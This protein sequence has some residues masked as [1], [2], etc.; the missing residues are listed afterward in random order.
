[1]TSSLALDLIAQLLLIERR[2]F[3]PA[4]WVPPYQGMPE[5]ERALVSAAVAIAAGASGRARVALAN[6]DWSSAPAGGGGIADRYVAAALG[7]CALGL[8]F[9]WFPGDVGATQDDAEPVPDFV[10]RLDGTPLSEITVDPKL[11]LVRVAAGLVFRIH[12]SR[13][14]VSDCQALPP[15][16]RGG[17]EVALMTWRQALAEA[18]PL[19]VGPDAPPL[20]SAVRGYARV[21]YADLLFRA[22]R[23]EQAQAEL[24]AA[25]A[26]APDDGVMRAHA[27]LVRGDWAATMDLC[28]GTGGAA[29]PGVPLA[30][31]DP[32]RVAV[33]EQFWRAARAGYVELGLRAGTAAADLRLAQVVP[34]QIRPQVLA[35]A[36]SGAL[37]AGDEALSWLARVHLRV[38]RH[39]RWESVSAAESE[40][41]L[42]ALAAW[43]APG[44]RSYV[45]GLIRL[46]AAAA[47]GC[48]AVGDV[49]AGRRLLHDAETVCAQLGMP[50]ERSLLTGAVPNVFSTSYRL[51]AALLALVDV[52]AQVRELGEGASGGLRAWLSA[53]KIATD[54]YRDGTRLQHAD[55]VRH[56]G[57]LLHQLRSTAPEVEDQFEAALLA[58][59][60]GTVQCLVRQLE[61]QLP[62]YAGLQELE[63]G[64][65]PE[66]AEHFERALQLAV[67]VGEDALACRLLMLLDRADEA[68]HL[69][70]RTVPSMP[71]DLAAELLVQVGDAPRALAAWEARGPVTSDPEC[72]WEELALLAEIHLGLGHW[73]EAGELA[74]A[75]VNGFE[76]RLARL[77]RDVL[78]VQSGEDPGVAR[79]Y[80][81]AVIA[82]VELA[83][84][85]SSRGDELR[86]AVERDAAFHAADQCRSGLLVL[87]AAVAESRSLPK[88]RQAAAVWLGAGADW[89]AAV[90]RACRDLF[91]AAGGVARSA[92]ARDQALAAEDSLAAAEETLAREAPQVLTACGLARAEP[93]S[94][95]DRIRA[96]LPV[97]S[98][99]LAYHTFGNELVIFALT[100]DGMQV[101]R[102]AIREGA[103]AADVRRIHSACSAPEAAP[104]PNLL[105][106]LSEQ[107]LT[108]VREVVNDS[109]QVIVVPHRSLIQLP[110]HLL[111]WDG[112]LLGAERVVSMLPSAQLLPA[113]APRRTPDL[114]RGSLAV[115]N[116]SFAA[117]RGLPVLPGTETEARAVSRTLP[118]SRLLLGDRATRAEVL[119]AARGVCVLHLATHGLLDARWPSLSALALAGSDQLSIADLMQAAVGADVVVLSACRTGQT[120]TTVGGDLIGL[121]RAALV[122]GV[123]HLVVSL[124]PLDDEA[125]CLLVADLAGRLARG[126][127]VAQAVHAAR[128]RI[129]ALDGLG[130]HQAYTGLRTASGGPQGGQGAR[131]LTPCVAIDRVRFAEAPYFWAPIIHIGC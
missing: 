113:V 131:D 73:A 68:R 58:Q 116:P 74:D 78:R 110:W 42:K 2:Q 51:L 38:D 31:G 15:G 54:V 91:S 28:P 60:L 10:P 45:R 86:A 30:L 59:A 47:T 128:L 48:R 108:P 75:A 114:D 97:D 14:V 98:A 57:A 49:V 81:V 8:E 99:M 66:A 11:A 121:T 4:L 39:L 127:P 80:L 83:F 107:W 29:G 93:G 87:A 100:R 84:Q 72:P 13:S 104:D 94:N 90:E 21:L 7:A 9:N 50:A 62:Y 77:G 40:T 46:L 103:L 112:D 130:R 64:R 24:A 67:A 124:W 20:A 44:S 17:V 125:G 16:Q 118:G 65:L 85:A 43:V 106:L 119:D 32:V 82:H 95:A 5:R 69:A 41:E 37:A 96:A 79:A 115:G 61:V 35:T 18:E 3:D 126:E 109:R 22:A 105:A 1:M 117:E 76:E 34:V 88:A 56:S 19:C 6:I 92:Q 55:F 25:L 120:A 12:F 111:P 26:E 36:V 23:R 27:D 122:A 53:L 123:A 101:R 70:A 63:S 52:G 102:R 89:A 33:A 129:R 71:S